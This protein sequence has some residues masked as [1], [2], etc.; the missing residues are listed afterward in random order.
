MCPGVCSWQNNL[1]LDLCALQLPTAVEGRIFLASPS[2]LWH[3]VEKQ[4]SSLSFGRGSLTP[5]PKPGKGQGVPTSLERGSVPHVL[6]WPGLP[7]GG[8]SARSGSSPPRSPYPWHPAP[9]ATCSWAFLHP[10]PLRV[11]R[12][13]Q[14][15]PWHFSASFFLAANTPLLPQFFFFPSATYSS[16]LPKPTS[17][18]PPD[19]VNLQ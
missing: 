9:A 15:M 14:S 6:A 16:L 7:E 18:V 8:F 2:L 11:F 10:P 13:A 12:A 1:F 4:K 17:S 5:S 3:L 19:P